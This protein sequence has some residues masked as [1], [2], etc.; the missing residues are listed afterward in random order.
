MTSQTTTRVI[1][2]RNGKTTDMQ[3][4]QVTVENLRRVFQVC[5]LCCGLIYK[6]THA[7]CFWSVGSGVHLAELNANIDTQLLSTGGSSRGVDC[8]GTAHFPQE[9]HFHLHSMPT[10]SMLVVEGPEIRGG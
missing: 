6:H 1:L 4:Q 10:Y 3:I 2:E 9:G 8:D 7:I 5:K